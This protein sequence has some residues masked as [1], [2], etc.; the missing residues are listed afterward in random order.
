M[1]ERPVAFEGPNVGL[2]IALVAL[3]T[4]V[5]LLFVGPGRSFVAELSGSVAEG[6]ARAHAWDER[7]SEARPLLED[8]RRAW[9]AGYARL[10]EFGAPGEDE[11]GITTWV[12]AALRAPSVRGLEVI[13]DPEN[14]DGERLELRSPDG[15]SRLAFESVFVRL[16]FDSAYEDLSRLLARIEDP[17]S[18]FQLRR[19]EVKR[20]QREVRVQL[21]L[22]LWTRREIQS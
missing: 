1:G 18:A 5:L 19:I 10:R 21:D 14:D 2:C 9:S 20:N 8:D 6:E 3:W 15:E 11:L 16:R 22:D 17:A 13:R 12:A 7:F 4:A